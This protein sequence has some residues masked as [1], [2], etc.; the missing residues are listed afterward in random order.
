MKCIFYWK[1]VVVMIRTKFLGETTYHWVFLWFRFSYFTPALCLQLPHEALLTLIPVWHACL[2]F[3]CT[4]THLHLHKP[5][6]SR[7]LFSSSFF[8]GDSFTWTDPEFTGQRKAFLKPTNRVKDFAVFP[9]LLMLSR[10]SFFLVFSPLRG[11]S[12]T[13]EVNG[14][15]WIIFQC[16]GVKQCPC[17]YLRESVFTVL[18]LVSFAPSPLSR[19]LIPW[20]FPT[21]FIKSSE[22]S[23]QHLASHIK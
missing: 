19:G 6:G 21:F 10:Q 18:L 20:I 4:N 14:L 13:L 3:H 12:S 8:G 16:N 2:Y 11:L 17:H 9:F 1:F 22:R 5:G 15:N 23:D 7:H